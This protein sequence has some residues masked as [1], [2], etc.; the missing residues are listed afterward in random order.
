MKT[1]PEE[2]KFSREH[3][4]IEMEDEFIG[5]CGLTSAKQE[6]MGEIVFV[7]LPEINMEIRMGEKVAMLESDKDLLT[8]I[9]PVSG[10]IIDINRALEINP[11]TINTDPYGEGW[12]YKLDVK[13]PTE[14]MD[15][16][17]EQEYID[18]ILQG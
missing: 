16:M 12:I 1:V 2:R 7:D 18:Y 17:D 14:F 3:A 5:R 4:W 8:L 6:D 9:S 10:V 15:L 13:E 11:G